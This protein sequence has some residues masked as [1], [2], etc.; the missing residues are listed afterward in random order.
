MVYDASKC[1]LNK[2]VWAPN[3]FMSSPDSLYNNLD[4]GTYMGDLD[5]GECFLNFPLDISIRP[6]AG[7]DLTPY[8][9]E[10]SHL[11][12]ERWGRCL[13]GFTPLPYNAAQSMGW[14]EAIIWGIPWIYLC[15]SIGIILNVPYRMST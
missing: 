12:W 2:L 15:L 3:F 1:G 13:M 5:L 9:G 11:I 14:T 8:F 7:V 10:N 4:S 6:Y